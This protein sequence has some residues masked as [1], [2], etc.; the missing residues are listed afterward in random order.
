MEGIDRHIIIGFPALRISGLELPLLIIGHKSLKAISDHIHREAVIGI[1]GVDGIRKITENI[2]ELLL[3]AFLF[4]LRFLSGR[5]ASREIQLLLPGAR[6]RPS[7]AA[8]GEEESR[9]SGQHKKQFPIFFHTVL[10]FR[11]NTT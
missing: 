7:A 6:V 4:G 10:L 5:T 1:A 3:S 8:G 11:G 9:K 2:G